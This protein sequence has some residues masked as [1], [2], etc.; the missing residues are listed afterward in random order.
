[1]NGQRGAASNLRLTYREFFGGGDGKPPENFSLSTGRRRRPSRQFP[2]R[3]A[4]RFTRQPFA[5]VC[6]RL[7]GVFGAG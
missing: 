4:R 3:L 6:N 2:R 1:L 7:R 5:N